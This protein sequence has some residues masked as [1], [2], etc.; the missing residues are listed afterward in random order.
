MNDKRQFIQLKEEVDFRLAQRRHLRERGVH[1]IVT[2]SCHISGTQCAPG[3]M[4][5]DIALGGQTQP[6][7]FG[8]SH[9]S[10]LLMDCLCRYRVSL[11][12]LRIEQIMN[13]DPFYVHY[14][15][16]R[17]GCNQC[18]ARPDRRTIRV[19]VRRI[20]KQMENVF[21]DAGINLDP[22]R[23][24]ISEVTDS[25]T[26]LYKLRATIELLHIEK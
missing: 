17:I 5:E 6:H 23:V 14:A 21:R 25:N 15:S 24:L 26:I 7:S 13:T 19:Y 18:L 10:L 20:M 9:M 8:F 12:A 3:E 11:S 2:H 4:I 16:N 22:N 1:L